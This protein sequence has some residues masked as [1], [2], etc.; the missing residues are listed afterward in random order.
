MMHIDQLHSLLRAYRPSSSTEERHLLDMQLLLRG[1]GNPCDRRHYTPGHFTAS[2]F[3]LSPARDALL[4]VLHRALGRWL[5]PGGHIESQDA[6]AAA[7]AQREVA[8]ETGVAVVAGDGSLFDV[9][10]HTIPERSETP[11]H[12]HFDL[13][14]LFATSPA[15][16]A[17]CAPAGD[18]GAARWVPLAEVPTLSDRSVTR[19]LAKL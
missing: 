16:A 9:D 12:T 15:S 8:E 7:A 11:S 1:G 4:L 18:V 2:A 3:V 10:I 5:Q 13:R 6:S 14:F 19:I 17:P